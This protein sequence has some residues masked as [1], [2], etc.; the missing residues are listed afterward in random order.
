MISVVMSTYNDSKYIAQTI[1]SI[2]AQTYRDFEFIIVNDGSTD[3]TLEIIQQYAAKDERIKIIDQENGERC[4]ARNA[5]MQLAQGKWIAASDADDISRP[6][7]LE[8]QLAMA[9]AHPEATVIG[10]YMEMIDREGRVLSHIRQGPTTPEAFAAYDRVKQGHITIYNTGAFFRR[11]LALELGGYDEDYLNVEDS[12]LWDRM[13]EYGPILIVPE[14]LVQYRFHPG[15]SSTRRFFK[16]KM[17]A[18][19]ITERHRLAAAGTPKTLEQYLYD[20]T[21]LP[22]PQKLNRNL[23]LISQMY[24]RRASLAASTKDYFNAARLTA[25]SVLAHPLWS[26]RRI[27]FRATHNKAASDNWIGV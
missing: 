22:L 26:I 11:D 2:L 1:E 15:N 23:R 9:E 13:S 25:M 7:R 4:R 18:S 8:K 17:L 21:H 12:E 27:L 14:P 24:Y 16:Q 10:C 5:G 20:Y 6:D 3:N 19:F